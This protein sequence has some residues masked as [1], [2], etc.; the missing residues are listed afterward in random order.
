M[1]EIGI[2]PM[3]ENGPRKLKFFDSK[4]RKHICTSCHSKK[5]MGTC[6]KC[7]KGPKP[8]LYIDRETRKNICASCYQKIKRR[9]K[10][11]LVHLKPIKP[12]KPVPAKKYRKNPYHTKESV[13][14]ALNARTREGKK[15][16]ARVL[17]SKDASLYRKALKFGVV[18]PRA[19]SNT[20]KKVKKAAVVASSLVA[21]RT[22][23]SDR[24]TGR[25][26][27]NPKKPG[28][29]PKYPTREEVI[30]DLNVREAEGKDNFPTT[31]NREDLPLYLA[32]LR[33]KV[34]LLTKRNPPTIYYRGDLVKNQ[35]DLSL[36]GKIGNVLTSDKKETRVNFREEGGVVRVYRKWENLNNITLHARNPR[37]PVETA[38]REVAPV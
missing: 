16:N 33:F 9:E 12:A 10:R 18:L 19:K 21:V 1:P 29:K 31:L 3:C 6:P 14:E 24:I 37:M 25:W 35:K 38:E 17:L 5:R 4:T 15:N 28:P 36:Y 20:G 23:K 30:A 27:E 26:E 2:C 34:D 7:N 11:L 32:A 22:V 13:I 8:L